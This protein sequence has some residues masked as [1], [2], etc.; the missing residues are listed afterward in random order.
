MQRI[1][2]KKLERTL[3]LT[4]EDAL[5]S[6]EGL[7]ILT[8]AGLI[9]ANKANSGHG[10]FV[11]THDNIEVKEDN[12]IV[13]DKDFACWTGDVVAADASVT[14]D[15]VQEYQHPSADIFVMTLDDNGNINAEPC[16]PAKVEYLMYTDPDTNKTTQRTII[17]CYGHDGVI[18]KNSV[19]LVDY[20]IRRMSGATQVEI[21][22]DKFSGSYYIEAETLFRRQGDNYDMPAE[23]VIPNGKIQ[24]NFTFTMANSGDPSTFT[25]TVDAMPDYTKFDRTHK[26]LAMIQVIEDEEEED[27]GVREACIERAISTTALGATVKT[28]SNDETAAEVEITGTKIMENASK[29]KLFNANNELVGKKA[30]VASIPMDGEKCI[31]RQVN[32]ALEIYKTDTFVYETDDNEFVKVKEYPATG[33]ADE[34]EFLVMENVPEITIEVNKGGTINSVSHTITG[35]TTKTYTIK[36]VDIKFA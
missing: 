31:I 2:W 18:K 14:A 11:H 12:K 13:I 20:Y 29:N 21:T 27:E 9:A 32:P 8:G 1:T 36:P 3:T 23:F 28:L 10:M 25:F 33:K 7:S 22:A 24:S 4:M 15:E 6:M 34:Y 17:T 35:G 19:V 30:M 26:V 16:I 5:L